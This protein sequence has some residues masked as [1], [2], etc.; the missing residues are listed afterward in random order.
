MIPNWRSLRSSLTAR[1]SSDVT[2]SKELPS[3][4]AIPRKLIC[5]LWSGPPV[6]GLEVIL[7]SASSES[8]EIRQ[9]RALPPIHL[10][11]LSHRGLLHPLPRSLPTG[12]QERSQPFRVG[13]VATHFHSRVARGAL[14]LDQ[15]LRLGPLS[16]WCRQPRR[17]RMNEIEA[18]AFV[19]AVV[20]RWW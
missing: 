15:T 9:S 20:W 17:G 16:I 6:S 7:P 18:L 5:C 1:P 14:A 8:D 4:W 11:F 12:K 3:R 2:G 13:L 10:R 19:A